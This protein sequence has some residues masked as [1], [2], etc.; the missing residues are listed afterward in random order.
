M[1][2]LQLALLIL[3]ATSL[4]GAVL[5]QNGKPFLGR[6]AINISDNIDPNSSFLDDVP[7]SEGGD[8]SAS[9]GQGGITALGTFNVTPAVVPFDPSLTSKRK[10]AVS[11]NCI[12]SFQFDSGNENFNISFGKSATKWGQVVGTWT[13][14]NG[15]T[16]DTATWLDI[17]KDTCNDAGIPGLNG[18]NLDDPKY[19][20]S[21]KTALA[22][23]ANALLEESAQYFNTTLCPSD[24]Q[25]AT[26]PFDD[27]WELR[28][29]QAMP[30][31][32]WTILFVGSVVTGS[33]NTA[34]YQ[35]AY[36]NSTAW[37]KAEAGVSAAS[38][39][40][41]GG[42]LNWIFS[43][44]SVPN[45]DRQLTAGGLSGIRRIGRAAANSISQNMNEMVSN[46][47]NGGSGGSGGLPSGQTG[48]GSTAPC[49]T[50][51]DVENQIGSLS[52]TTGTD[53]VSPFALVQ[54]SIAQVARSSS[55]HF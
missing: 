24:N 23:N 48:A 28:K 18:H 37:Q 40:F 26:R 52:T 38:L 35:T 50:E 54:E 29:L 10:R 33:L 45:I 55:C 46:S 25:L 36:P 32:Y 20:A 3:P 41:A 31:N 43:H 6:Q 5:Q 2:R 42:V 44:S 11:L 30:K 21:L 51:A 22:T 7:V 1:V 12:E 13:F 4:A 27:R 49:V 17:Y 34:M 39:L 16:S 47:G 8:E 9:G 19:G 15:T 14:F 53:M